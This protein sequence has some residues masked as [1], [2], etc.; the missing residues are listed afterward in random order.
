MTE[1]IE[2]VLPDEN[3]PDQ[4]PKG[5]QIWFPFSKEWSDYSS[6]S[7]PAQGQRLT[8]E[9]NLPKSCWQGVRVRVPVQ[10]TANPEI[11]PGWWR[12]RSGTLA[13]VVACDESASEEDYWIGWAIERS[14]SKPLGASWYKN[15]DFCI[16]LSHDLNLVEFLPDCTGWNWNS[17]GFCP[18]CKAVVVSREK[19]PY[20]NDRC[21]NGHI[22]P[23]SASIKEL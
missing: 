20:G 22:Y 15:G 12:T 8:T 11:K 3:C 1:Y 23:S 13:K 9:E 2:Y 5:S 16:G 6:D 14:E 17:Y 7:Q 21:Q 10:V 18:H 4:L 19:R